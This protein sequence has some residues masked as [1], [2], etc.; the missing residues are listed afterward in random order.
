MH[1][2]V[3]GSHPDVVVPR[4][5]DPGRE[6][7]HGRNRRQSQH[8]GLVLA[9]QLRRPRTCP[10]DQP[11]VGPGQP[12]TELGIEILRRYEGPAGQERGLQELVRPLHHALA[13][14]IVG[15]DLHDPGREHPGE[16]RDP[17]G[18]TVPPPDAG[19]VVPDQPPRHRTQGPD[20]LPHPGQQVP[21]HPGRDHPGH[22]EPRMRAH[23]H[24][25]RQNP[26]LAATDPDPHLGEPQ[27]ALRLIPGFVTEPVRRIGRG[28]LRPDP[29]HVL[30]EPRRGPGPAHTL[31]QHRRRHPRVLPQQRTDGRF[32][33]F[34]P[35]VLR[36]THIGR[37]P[38]SADCLCDRVPGNPQPCR[39]RPHRLTLGKM[40]PPNKR[41]ILHCDH[42][43][44]RLEQV[45]QFST[46]TMAQFSTVTDTAGC[47]RT[48]QLQSA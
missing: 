27:V 7:G 5:P 20:Q 47:P 10:P 9:D 3:V 34:D 30:P 41:P 48:G 18:I 6:P 17:G 29:G 37:R 13:L 46:V 26:R 45:A 25:H 19:F 35:R 28:I 15:L 11:G 42:P 36:R 44:N 4:Q 22:D 14:R 31:R 43:P 2:V 33:R 24:Q 38:V 40:Q 1:G 8:R 39:Y 16:R 23:H 12:L 21:G 32:H